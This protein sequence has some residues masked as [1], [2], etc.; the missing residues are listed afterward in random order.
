MKQDMHSLTDKIPQTKE[1]N[2]NLELYRIIVMLLIIAHHYVVNSGL[3]AQMAKF[4]HAESSAYLALL[5]LWGKT[6]INCFTLITGYYMCR[7]DISARKFAKLLFEV[8]F[9]RIVFM[10]IFNVSGYSEF[11]LAQVADIFFPVQTLTT[12]YISCFLVFYLFIPFL[13]ILIRKMTEK[14]H[15]LLMALCFFMYTVLGTIPGCTVTM[16][17]VSWFC[18]LYIYAAYLRLYP[19]KLFENRRLWGWFTLALVVLSAFLAVFLLR[20]QRRSWAYYSSDSNKILALLLGLSSFLFSKNLKIPQSRLINTIAASTFGVLLIHAQSDSM[21][22]WLWVDTL[23]NTSWFGSPW[24]IVH[25]VASVAGVFLAC[26]IID[27]CR[28]RFIE[29]PFFRL[30]DRMAPKIGLWLKEK[31]LM[32]TKK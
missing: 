31:Y 1:R 20:T 12:G 6:G 7:A 22:Q 25:S 15:L 8:L 24:L 3:S 29:K 16:N 18:V 5:G 26:F 9:Y 28:I 13:N 21:R 10:V 27:W 17:Y 4:P 19:K 23:K 30:Y 14:Q 32:Y 11:T 2:S